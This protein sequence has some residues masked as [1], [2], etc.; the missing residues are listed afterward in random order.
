MSYKKVMNFHQNIIF[1]IKIQ[2]E[3][4]EN[5]NFIVFVFR[6]IKNRGTK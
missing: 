1:G 6:G 2:K 4:N 3:M 5:L